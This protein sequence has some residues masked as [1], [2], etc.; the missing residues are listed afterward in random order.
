MGSHKNIIKKSNLT[1]TYTNLNTI[2]LFTMEVYDEIEV[3]DMEWNEDDQKF[4]FPCPCGDQFQ[5]TLVSN[6]HH[7]SSSY[8]P[9]FMAE[10]EE[11]NDIATCPSCSLTIRVIYE[12]VSL[13][14]QL[15]DSFCRKI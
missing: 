13:F 14:C 3:E 9:S 1:K 2:V 12:M 6:E 5:I 10:L 15:D 4:Y 11:E 8:S 7:Q